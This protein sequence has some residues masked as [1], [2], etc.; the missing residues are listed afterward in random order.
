MTE[1]IARAH[2]ERLCSCADRH[3]GSTGNLLATDY[4]HRHLTGLRWTVHS[5]ELT[6]TGWEHG[7]ATLEADGQSIAAHVGYYSLPC[8]VEA[9]IVSAG[10][11]DELAACDCQGKLLLVHDEL[12]REQLISPAFPFFQIEAHQRIYALLREKRPAAILASTGSNPGFAGG[13]CP[14]PWLDDGLFDIPHAYCH[15]RELPRLL[16]A[17]HGK[18]RFASTRIPGTAW[19]VRATR[20]T[21]SGPRIVCTAHVDTKPATPGALDNAAGVVTLLLLAERLQTHTGRPIELVFVNG[22]DYWDV[23]G[24]KLLVRQ[25][26]GRWGDIELVVNLD[27]LGA[28]G[29]RTGYSAF[30]L[31]ESWQRRLDTAV[32]ASPTG[33]PMASWYASDH[34]VFVQQECPAVAIT[35]TNFDWLCEHVTHTERDT[36]DGVDLQLLL[37]AAETIERLLV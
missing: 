5:D 30:G 22:E 4:I 17:S 32:A 27:A 18:L 9:D 11:I 13:L 23:T 28:K 34:M 2:M 3:P 26:E 21:A 15:E 7:E 25:N 33:E 24:E 12:T 19:Q 29:A 31:P 8:D 35:S 16:C 1:T 36:P 37:D 10:T 14:F 6:V 20:G